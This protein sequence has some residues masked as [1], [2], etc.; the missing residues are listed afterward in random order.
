MDCGVRGGYLLEPLSV[1]VWACRRA[2]VAPGTTVL[3]TGVGSIGLI[4]A[5]TARA[6]VPTRS[7]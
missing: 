7:P 5:Q 6:Y 4:A 1:G 2:E 3:V